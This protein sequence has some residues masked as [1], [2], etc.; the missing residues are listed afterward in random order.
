MR[1]RT[2]CGLE[3][4]LAAVAGDACLSAALLLASG[5]LPPLHGDPGAL[6]MILLATAGLAFLVAGRPAAWRHLS[7]LPLP[8]LA[9]LLP[10]PARAAALGLG[11]ALLAWMEPGYRRA[12]F[13]SRLALLACGLGLALMIPQAYF[14]FDGLARVQS[15]VLTRLSGRALHLG[16]GPLLHIPLFFLLRA[17]L[18]WLAG[19]GPRRLWT[20]GGTLIAQHLL[21][22]QA[23][24]LGW[25]TPG[26]LAGWVPLISF[27]LFFLADQMAGEPVVAGMKPVGSGRKRLVAA[28]LLPIFPALGLALCLAPPPVRLDGQAVGIRQAGLWSAELPVEEDGAAPRLGGL[29]AV[30]RTWGAKVQVLDDAALTADPACRVLF[31][32]QPDQALTPELR[33]ALRRWLEA[34]GVLIAVGEHTHVHGIGVGLGSLLQDYHI[35]LRDDSAIPFLNGWQWGHNLRMHSSP[36][37]AGLRDSQHLGVSIGASL[38][39]SYP[40]MPLVTGCLAFADTGDPSNVRGRLGNT[41]P[42][43]GERLGSVPLV[44]A[45]PVGK[46]LLVVLGDK[47]PLMSLN[48]PLVWPFYLNLGGRLQDRPWQDG[49]GLRLTLLAL[50]LATLWPVLRG[51]PPREELAVTALLLPLLSWPLFAPG[52]PPPAQAARADIVWIDHS[53]Q[54]SWWH[55]PDHD[56]SQSALV[57]ETYLAGGLPL[58]LHELDGA[59]LEGSRTL[60]IAGS[61]RPYSRAERETLQAYVEHGGRLLIAGDGRRTAGLRGLLDHFGFGLGETPLGSAAEAVSRTRGSD[62]RFWEAWDVQDLRGG[63]DTLVQCWGI[64]IVMERAMGSG[65]LVVVGDERAFSRWA[66]EGE[67]RAGIWQS[68]A[69]R[70]RGMNMG[71]PRLIPSPARLQYQIRVEAGAASVVPPAREGPGFAAPPPPKLREQELRP[72]TRWALQMLGLNPASRDAADGGGIQ[73]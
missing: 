16:E 7:L 17:G 64:P 41:R 73:P 63:A 6:P 45:E 3:S 13:L 47:S 23:W 69:T 26:Q 40:A 15:E 51:L 61:A 46:G 71:A 20:S 2:E 55:P 25:A 56:W 34:G 44:A 36:A 48:N 31:V 59:T 54:P 62:F 1:Q 57:R 60:L 49:R 9:A 19:A 67:G 21:L 27:L 30:L 68:T 33:T 14:I 22:S 38:D 39:V 37:T 5:L 70:F 18:Q 4:G 52:T 10:V 66:L 72:H 50:L 12:S 28:L 11:L 32:V 35:K 58:A 29:L 8:M 42:D 43:D 24:R 53:H 65:R